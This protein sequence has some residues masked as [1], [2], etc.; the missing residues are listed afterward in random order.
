VAG[1]GFVGISKNWDLLTG[2]NNILKPAI[3]RRNSM[4]SVKVI[5]GVVASKAVEVKGTAVATVVT[6]PKVK[7]VVASKAV[8]VKGEKTK[9]ITLYFGKEWREGSGSW[10]CLQTINKAKKV[11]L[12]EA[13]K[14]ATAAGW[15][16]SN[17]IGRM[18]HLLIENMLR[19]FIKKDGEY[20]LAK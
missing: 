19:G 3:T 18:K 12:E 14:L 10:L 15:K 13:V 6:A 17:P 2:S 1:E 20:Y 9:Y 4:K 7:G 5:K 16:S 11:T 8:E